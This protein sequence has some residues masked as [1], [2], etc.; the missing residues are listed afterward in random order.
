MA[1]AVVRVSAFRG[2]A[3]FPLAH[4]VGAGRL[5]EAG[6]DVELDFTA[7]SDALMLGLVDGAFDVVQASPDNFVAWRDRTSAPIRIWYGG[8]SGPISL[9]L[10]PA[11]D[12]IES[13]RG[14]PVA[15]DYPDT[16]WAPIMLRILAAHGVAADEVQQVATGATAKVFAALVDGRSP[17]GMLNEPWATRAVAA[18]CRVAADHHTVAPGMQTSAGASLEPWLDGN[19]RL[20]RTILRAIAAETRRLLDPGQAPDSVASLAAYLETTP[21]EARALLARAAEPGRGW[22][23]DAHPDP[24]GLGALLDLRRSTLEPPRHT[25]AEYLTEVV[26]REAASID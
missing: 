9:V 2:I 5:R 6:V 13:L 20:A 11:V 24:V 21:D 3:A 1:G 17:A 16:G 4:A 15:V 25:V 19:R 18:G 26:Y 10:G 8:S 12:G 23:P 7:S 22:P 14:G